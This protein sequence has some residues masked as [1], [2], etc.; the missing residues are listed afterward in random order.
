M[1]VGFL[2]IFLM[3]YVLMS[4]KCNTRLRIEMK[5][6]LAVLALGSVL[7]AGC[8]DVVKGVART[9]VENDEK[10]KAAQVAQPMPEQGQY[11]PVQPM[12]PVQ[13][14]QPMQPV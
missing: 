8:D 6:A 9:I 12:Q 11:V 10:Q 13:S 4:P 2:L 1:G 3:N 7:L 5:K 14:V